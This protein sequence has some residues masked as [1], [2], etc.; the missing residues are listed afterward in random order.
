MKRKGRTIN[1]RE[2]VGFLV[3]TAESRVVAP[4]FTA[5]KGQEGGTQKPLL[6]V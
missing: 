3:F 4:L 1:E 2:D 6:Y 5:V